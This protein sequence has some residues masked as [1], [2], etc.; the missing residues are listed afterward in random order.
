MAVQLVSGFVI[1][2]LIDRNLSQEALGLWDLAWSIVIY[3]TLIQMGVTSS[4]N[5]YVAF[6]RAR[7]DF[8]GVNRVVTSVAFVMRGMGA[9]AVVV[10]RYVPGP[11]ERCSTAISETIFPKHAGWC[12]CWALMSPFK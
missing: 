6:H 2:R 1:P 12:F 5:R 7:D 4:I 8:D 9:V 11:S 3:F 10:P